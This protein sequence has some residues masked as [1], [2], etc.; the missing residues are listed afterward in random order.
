MVKVADQLITDDFALYQ[1]DCVECLQAVPDNS[2]GLS[3]FSPPFPGMYAY[4]NSP[5]DMG[6][7]KSLD[8]MIHHFRFLVGGPLL[9]VLMP[10]RNVCVHLTQSP[11]FKWSDGYIGLKDYRGEVIR[12]FE[13]CGFIYYGEVC[14][15]KDPQVKAQRTKDASLQFKSLANDSSRMRMALADY[16]LIFKKPG[17][18]TVPIR[19][20][21]SHKYDNQGGWISNEEWIEWA[22]P[23]WYRATKDYPGGIR[24]TDVLNVACARESDDERHLCPLQL[25]VIERCVKLWSAPGETVLSPFA[26]IGSEGYMSLKLWR[27]FV[28]IEL[29]RSYWKTAC[30]NLK[31]AIQQRSSGELFAGADAEAVAEDVLA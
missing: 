17:D 13:Q 26:G 22:A 18:N 12:M 21:I 20:G 3:V 16:I 9:R 2:I 7:V 27:R 6:N 28:G 8:E 30:E 19:A 4:T 25:G 14:I 24:E 10:G 15:D 31:W 29:K 11:A 23:V 5:R 1:G